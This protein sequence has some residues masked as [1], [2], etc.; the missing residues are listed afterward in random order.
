MRR[1]SSLARRRS[2]ALA[3]PVT[4]CLL[5]LAACGNPTVDACRQWQ[6]SLLALDCVPDDYEVGVDCSEYQDYPCDASP[7]FACL[8]QSYSCS[9]AGDF[10]P[11]E[12]NACASLQGC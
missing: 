8:E 10:V 5:A 12:P 3:L 9:E 6:A 1:R 7:Y 4:A 2:R 11:P